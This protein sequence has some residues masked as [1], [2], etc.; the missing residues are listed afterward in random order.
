M[1]P[2]W[3]YRMGLVIVISLL[4]LGSAV[5]AKESIFAL[6]EVPISELAGQMPSL[7]GGHQATCVREPDPNVRV[8]PVLKSD[9]PV[10]GSA[11]FG[12][13]FEEK[14]PALLCYLV[15][16]ESG[17]PGT[18]YDRLY[19]DT[20]GDRDLSN[21]APALPRKDPPEELLLRYTSIAGQ[22]LFENVG[23]PLPFG[24]EGMRPLEVTPRLLLL[25]GGGAMLSFV[26]AT[27]RRGRVQIGGRDYD[28][29][30]GQRHPFCGWFDH[31][32]TAFLIN[33][34][35]Q[36]TE[37]PP[38]GLGVLMA[39]LRLSKMYYRFTAT[40]AG[41][42]LIVRR[43]EGP[44]GELEI[45]GGNK[46][47]S[48][49]LTVVGSLRSRDAVI[50]VTEP[51]CRIPAGDYFFDSVK[52]SHGP[53]E[54]A[55]QQNDHT[56]GGFR[57]RLYHSRDCPVAI[58]EGK[59]FVLDFSNQPQ[60][61]FADP[62]KDHRVKL[63]ERMFVEA[64]LADPSLDFVVSNFS[65]ASQPAGTSARIQRT[66]LNPQVTISRSNGEVVDKGSMHYG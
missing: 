47:R 4:F 11:Q 30:L 64:V 51:T 52:I 57:S 28:V 44:M 53:F 58:R 48:A 50:G 45:G 49:D 18:G 36:R 21:D 43:Y 60:I 40:P 35:A 15:A 56:D 61:V 2:Q 27:V 7:A 55:I 16:D 37:A 41:D 14:N 38:A 46:F 33:P 5:G 63:G 19:V 12:S 6:E 23:I 3:E 42:K 59:R 39:M 24:S 54:F 25:K 29:I 10:Y 32:E 34:V 13:L 1:I 66:V 65:V 9:K 62:P 31:P 8:Y 22:V 26:P 17:G 20:N